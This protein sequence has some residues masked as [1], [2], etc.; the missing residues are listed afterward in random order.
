[1]GTSGV[2]AI[3]PARGGSKGLPGKNIL[4][5]GDLP[6]IAWTIHAARNASCV[7]RVVVTTDDAEIAAVAR[8]SGAEVPFLRPPE[9]ATDTATSADVADH[10]LQ[11]LPGFD[12]AVLLQPTSPF[13]TASDIDAARALWDAT[14]AVSC[15]SVCEA[16]Q[17]PWLMFTRGIEGGL[18]RVLPVPEAGLRRQDLASTYLLNGAIYLIQ[19][20]HFRATRQFVH[21]DTSGYVMPQD[22]SVDIDTADD[23]DAARAQL[24]AWGGT[25]PQT[26]A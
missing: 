7:A 20:D 26:G 16:T 12:R 10:V 19:T 23:L 1:M 3:I 14:G 24:A 5:L 22:R 9:L 2:L 15:V 4:P 13:R 17:S 8:A 18:D 11:A 6:L 25:V 21:S